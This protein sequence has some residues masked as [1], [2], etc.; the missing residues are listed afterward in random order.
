MRAA[1]ARLPAYCVMT[2]SIPAGSAG[3]AAGPMTRDGMAP[4]A[5]SMGAAMPSD[6]WVLRRNG[7]YPRPLAPLC[8]RE[9]ATLWD[10]TD[11]AFDPAPPR[12]PDPI[13]ID[14]DS[15]RSDVLGRDG[16]RAWD[17]IREERDS[18]R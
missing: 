2:R 1:V 7:S 8:T 18:G 3:T 14:W 6:L 16:A 4:V 17:P 10:L 9:G 12:S 15:I 11:P 13:E 5:C